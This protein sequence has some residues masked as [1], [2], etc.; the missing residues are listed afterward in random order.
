M[1]S[2]SGR[3]AIESSVSL[4]SSIEP[5]ITPSFATSSVPGSCP[6]E[7]IWSG[8]VGEHVVRADLH[9]LV[10]LADGVLDLE[11]LGGDVRVLR[12]VPHLHEHGE[13][14]LVGV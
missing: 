5:P 11:V 1:C 8:A 9:R 12:A 4:N 2:T 6:P 13:P 10:A 7:G 3:L 14:R